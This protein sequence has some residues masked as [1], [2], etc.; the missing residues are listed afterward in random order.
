MSTL[1]RLAV[2][3]AARS[4]RRRARLSRRTIVDGGH[5]VHYLEGGSG[6]PLVLLHG[7]ADDKSSFVRAAQQLTPGYRVILPDLAGHGDNVRDPALDYSIRGHV[8]RLHRLF[9]ALG[10]TRVHLGGNSM[11][12]HISA[13][14][15][16]HHPGR[17]A[18]VILVNA[19]GLTLDDHVVYAGFGAQMRTVADLEAVLDRVYYRRPR[20]P[21]FVAR[22]LVHTIGQTFDHTNAMV[23]AVTEGPDLALN[24]RVAEIAA[25]TLILW[26]R[27]DVVVRPNV[28]E[29]YRDRIAQATL[30]W[31][32]EAGHSPQLEVPAQVGTEIDRF[33]QVVTSRPT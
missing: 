6:A 33:L 15:A 1:G 27:H 18:S 22:H 11:G 29:A 16:I 32:D 3:L 28:A 26:G 8:E 2:S 30:V 13:A 24:D 5:V 23:R 7:L 12:G 10:L 25:P 17:V 19:P 21:G 9:D 31:L 20:I 4:D 14:Y